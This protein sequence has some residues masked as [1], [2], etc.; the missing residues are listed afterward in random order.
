MLN[1]A[2]S[3]DPRISFEVWGSFSPFE[4]MVSSKDSLEYRK[5]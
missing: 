4:S 1:E 5:Y 3:N 2:E